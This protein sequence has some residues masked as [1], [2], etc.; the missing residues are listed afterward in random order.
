MYL[1]IAG[2][3]VVASPI[4]I[5]TWQAAAFYFCPVMHTTDTSEERDIDKGI[6]QGLG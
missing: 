1:D 2:V 4:I 5:N 6:F 3:D